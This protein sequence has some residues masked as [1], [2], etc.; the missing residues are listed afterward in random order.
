MRPMKHTL[1]PVVLSLIAVAVL[2]LACAQPE[3]T[4]DATEEQPEPVEAA[5]LEPPEEALA[6]PDEAEAA[7]VEEFVRGWV[8]DLADD[9]GVYDIPAK[10]D[11]DLSGVLTAFH[12]VHRTDEDS[13]NVCVDF[14]SGDS[15]LDVDFHVDRTDEGL[16]ISEHFLHKIDGEVVE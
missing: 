10:G 12:T 3:T 16:K 4:P 13:F 7:E 9:E 1:H 8:A 6:D 5:S 14:Q 11:H 15:L 2:A